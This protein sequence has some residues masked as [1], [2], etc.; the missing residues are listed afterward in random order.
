MSATQSP[1]Y[2][3]APPYKQSYSD[4]VLVG[5]KFGLDGLFTANTT[6]NITQVRD[7]IARK[8]SWIDAFCGQPDFRFHQVSELY[9]GEGVGRRA[10]RIYLLHSPV[11]SIDRVE[12]RQA[13][14]G[15]NSRDAWVLGIAVGASQA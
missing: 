1:Q 9:D 15:A 5:R 4:E 3:P 14:G 11:I 7:V 8:D 12:Y 10:G 13:G 6:P 2:S